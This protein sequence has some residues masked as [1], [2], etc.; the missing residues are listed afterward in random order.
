M[1]KVCRRGEWGLVSPYMRSYI[2]E[3]I[4]NLRLSLL[5]S[6]PTE[7]T[8]IHTIMQLY[9]SLSFFR[10]NFDDELIFQIDKLCQIKKAKK[11]TRSVK[12]SDDDFFLESNDRAE[13]SADTWG[14]RKPRYKIYR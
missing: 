13:R 7:N 11:Q 8:I 4:I 1:R 12:T 6:R 5:Y 2:F 3:I 10:V 14:S 9:I